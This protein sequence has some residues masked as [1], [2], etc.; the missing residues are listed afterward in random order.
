VIPSLSLLFGGDSNKMDDLGEKKNLNEIHDQAN[1]VNSTG[2]LSR[3]AIPSESL[4]NIAA[5]AEST[6]TNA[7]INNA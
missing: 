2:S 7:L 1:I 5:L 3:P 4:K 6:N